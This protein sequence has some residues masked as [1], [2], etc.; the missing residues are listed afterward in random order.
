MADEGKANTFGGMLTRRLGLCLAAL[1]LLFLFP[2]AG[3]GKKKPPPRPP[4]TVL[5][6]TVTPTN[7]PIFQEW[8]GTI[9]G[10]VNAQIR[11]QVTGYLL[12][13]DYA[14]GSHVKKG[15]LLFQIDPRPFQAAL[16]QAKAKLAQDEAQLKNNRLDVQ[17]YTPLAKDNAISQQQLDN[18]IQATASTEA[19][20]KADKAA[21]ESAALNLGFTR[22][23]SPIDGLAGLAQVQIG[24]LVGPSSEVLTTVSAINP[25]RVF[26]QVS[27]QSYL[28]FWR[29]FISA[30]PTDPSPAPPLELILSDG[31]VY[32]EKGKFAF[33]D[34]QVN[35][36]T[37]TLQITSQFPNDQFLLRPGQYARI[38]A[39]T[40]V[41]ENTLLVPQRAVMELQGSYQLAVIGESNKVTLASVKVGRQVGTDWIIEDGLKPGA[42]IV[43]EGTQKAKAGT[44]VT[45]QLW[46]PPKQEDGE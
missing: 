39:Q 8:I 33:A 3:C 34:R 42:R 15:D 30:K 32:P 45:P 5:T 4:P 25:V 31:S 9:D 40:E 6:I 7:V 13:Q 18:A 43:V 21:I 28:T 11:A 22:I 26:F 10:S 41:K 14:E 37:G 36:N 35:V 24:N 20:V 16:D 29:Q 19:L 12:T 23:T 38:R 1:A 17:R 27:E 44:V 2:C 46:T